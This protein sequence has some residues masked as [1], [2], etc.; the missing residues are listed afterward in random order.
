MSE[1]AFEGFGVFRSFKASSYRI[2]GRPG[3]AEINSKN[4]ANIK[5]VTRILIKVCQSI[6]YNISL[7][8]VNDEIILG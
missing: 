4:S 5:E 1:E 8:K 3:R 2:F 7:S 6:L